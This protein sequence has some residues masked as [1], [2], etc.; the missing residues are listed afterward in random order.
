[1]PVLIALSLVFYGYWDPRF[2]ALL[3]PSIL[4]N[5]LATQVYGRTR[6]GFPLT[7]AIIANLAVLGAFK[8]SAFFA[9]NLEAITGFRPY[10]W[11]FALP[12][13]IS[14]FTFHHIMYL[15]DLKRGRAPFYPLDRYAL[16]ICFFPQA[17][18]GP[19]ARWNEVMH[20]FGQPAFGPG[21][22]RRVAE[23]V[24]FVVAGLFQKVALSDPLA[25][26][27]DP[28]YTRAASGAVSSVEAWAALGFAFQ[29]LFDFAG[30]SDM[31]IGLGLIFG[32]RLPRNFDAPFRTTTLLDFWQRWHMTLAR[33]LRDYVYV[34]LRSTEIGGRKMRSA[35]MLVAILLTMSLCGLW[36]GAGWTYIIWG[37]LQGIGLVFAALWRRYLPTP[38]AMIG[39]A[40]TV[41]F[42]MLTAVIFRAPTLAAA[43]HIFEGLTALPQQRVPGLTEFAIAAFC[44][45][46]LPPS[47][48][49]IAR[50]MQRPRAIVAYGMAALAAVCLLQI[51]RGPPMEFIYF[52][53]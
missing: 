37:T 40:A 35:R 28:I 48:Q 14:F 52:R 34:P 7:L 25:Q 5:W 49:I 18:S 43:G 19:I 47:H 30:Y 21:W 22:E 36:H 41:G 4:V 32:V 38:P 39:W 6:R 17:M 1:M 51:G 42:S 9:Q 2:L 13:G 23:G 11:H 45:V 12:L 53:F 27:L 20:Q 29:V 33:F 44:A 24:M 26:A 10:Y 31:A 8:Y 16:Y 46:V 50:L 3:I 15:V